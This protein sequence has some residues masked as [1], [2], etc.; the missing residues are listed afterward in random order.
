M[1]Q[2]D[3]TQ[4]FHSSVT[5]DMVCIRGRGESIGS[6]CPGDSGGGVFYQNGGRY[7]VVGIVSWDTG[8]GG[9]Q[10][11]RPTV[12]TRVT[13]VLAWIRMETNDSHVCTL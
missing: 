2:P 10:D 3:C 8:T 6:T 12:A 5:K 13:S 7:E 11:H 4:I 9:C 1:S